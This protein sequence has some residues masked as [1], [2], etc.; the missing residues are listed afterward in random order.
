MN[1][2]YIRVCTDSVFTVVSANIFSI[3]AKVRPQ[4]S[5]V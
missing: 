3:V 2:L 4:R 5:C 1:E